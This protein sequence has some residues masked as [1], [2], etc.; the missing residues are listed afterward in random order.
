LAST[1]RSRAGRIGALHLR[2][3]THSM[4]SAEEDAGARQLLQLHAAA[5]DGE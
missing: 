5:R 1:N 4:A 2:A 3:R